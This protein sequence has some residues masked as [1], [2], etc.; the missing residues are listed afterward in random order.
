MADRYKA[1]DVLAVYTRDVARHKVLSRAE[2]KEVGFRAM[3]GDMSAQ[4]DLVRANLRFVITIAKRYKHHGVP[5]MDL[6]QAGNIG[7]AHAATKYDPTLDNRFISYA[8]HW[9]CQQIQKEI[10][11]D[12][13]A[14]GP[15][16]TQMGRVRRVR[17]LQSE[18]RQKL[19]RELTMKEL[20]DET[21]YTKA[22]IR[23]A[24]E[25]RGAIQSLDAP[26]NPGDPSSTPLSQVIGYDDGRERKE[27]EEALTRATDHVLAEV[28]S[29][30]EKAIIEEY[31]GFDN[32]RELSLTEIG[33]NRDISRERARQLKERALRKLRDAEEHHQFLLEHFSMDMLA[34]FVQ[35]EAEEVE[36]EQADREVDGDEN[37]P[38]AR[39]VRPV[40]QEASE[41]ADEGEESFDED[42]VH[43]VCD[44]YVEQ[45]ELWEVATA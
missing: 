13:G 9:I 14:I 12:N 35:S 21:G 4:E 42:E 31:F 2:E 33:A 11:A 23:E 41:E 38:R 16:V 1:S 40:E 15:S 17:R 19:G 34:E 43:P 37:T 28:L 10:D 8:V 6:I 32:R 3:D 18:A 25:Y 36:E 26:V 39:P 22:R 45:C 27:A 24:Q 44:D 20:Q 29:P 7:L 5:L 30:R